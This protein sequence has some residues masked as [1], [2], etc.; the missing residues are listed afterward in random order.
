MAVCETTQKIIYV[1]VLGRE[2]IFLF[3]MVQVSKE[4]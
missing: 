4:R 2:A 1:E 3:Y